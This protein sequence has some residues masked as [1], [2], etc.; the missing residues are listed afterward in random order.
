M[1]PRIE[2]EYAIQ[3]LAKGYICVPLRV[4]GK[5]LDLQAM[6]YP[7][8]HLQA[9]RKDLKELAFRSIAF[10][11][12]QKPPTSEQTRRW[13]R[14]FAGNVGIV[15]GYSNLLILDFDDPAGYRTWSGR[16][17]HLTGRTP[18]AKSPNG[19]HIYLR[20]REPAV[21][22]SLYSGMR[23]VGHVKALGGY[24]VASPSVI[25]DGCSYSW[26]KGQ[27]PFDVDPHPVESL[28]SLSLRAV[29][30]FKYHYDRVLNRGFFEPQ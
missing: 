22:S 8:L 16:H 3:L 24:V 18:V 9:R 26:L 19:F 5:H 25:R 10:Q 11:L 12:S 30:P 20:T 23:R 4:G 7:P 1:Q 29:S 13:F 27:S 6:E 2:T 28:A 15:G 14:D 21:S 17:T